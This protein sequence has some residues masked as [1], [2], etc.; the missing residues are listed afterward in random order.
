MRDHNIQLEPDKCEFLKT[1]I[2]YLG[3]VISSEGILPDPS[4]IESVI[5]YPVPKTAK[6]VKAFLGLIGY[7]RRFIDR[8]SEMIY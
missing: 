7:Y 6:E 4:K 1:E 8:F 2:S 5:K 3:H